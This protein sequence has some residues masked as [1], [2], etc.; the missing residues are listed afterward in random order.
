[1][2]EAAFWDTPPHPARAAVGRAG[3]R[4]GRTCRSA[5][6]LKAFAAGACPPSPGPVPEPATPTVVHYRHIVLA[7][8]RAKPA[9]AS[10]RRLSIYDKT[11]RMLPLAV[12][13]APLC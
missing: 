11:A 5:A 2:S 4:G 9:N 7:D 10:N 12:V 6:A 1:M 8:R 13:R 3:L